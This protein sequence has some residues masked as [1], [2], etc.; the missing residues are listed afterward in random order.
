MI[1][2]IKYDRI[3]NCLQFLGQDKQ[4]TNL[5]TQKSF[6][7]VPSKQGFE[8]KFYLLTQREWRHSRQWYFVSEMQES[9]INTS[10]LHVR[11][12]QENQQRDLE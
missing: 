7:E 4:K 9:Y 5:D 3:K 6:M 10:K 1:N 8:A 2:M 11:V 12:Y